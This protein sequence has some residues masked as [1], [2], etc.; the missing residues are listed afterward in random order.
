MADDYEVSAADYIPT[1]ALVLDSAN[2]ALDSAEFSTDS[3]ADP[4]RILLLHL[5]HL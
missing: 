3:N 5:L 1:G 4:M 2:S